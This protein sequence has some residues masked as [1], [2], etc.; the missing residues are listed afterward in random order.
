MRESR[1]ASGAVCAARAVKP[2]IQATAATARMLPSSFMLRSIACRITTLAGDKRSELGINEM[3]GNR[4]ASREFRPNYLI[5][6][7]FTIRHADE[8]S[9]LVRVRFAKGRPY[10]IRFN[11]HR[12]ESFP[13]KYQNPPN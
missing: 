3:K 7:V 2:Q 4:P 11:W 13:L 6:A 12:S 9:P 5:N 1:E 8:I 10:L